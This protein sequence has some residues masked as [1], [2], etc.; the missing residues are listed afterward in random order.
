MPLWQLPHAIIQENES[1]TATCQENS[2]HNNV[3]IPHDEIVEN[4]T[5]EGLAARFCDGKGAE[6]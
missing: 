6:K 4:I 2:M 1:R 3:L 5:L